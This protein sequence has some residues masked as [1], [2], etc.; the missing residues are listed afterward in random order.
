VIEYKK[1]GIWEQKD[2]IESQIQSLVLEI[3]I[4]IQSHNKTAPSSIEATF[5]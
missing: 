4:K 3:D 5:E 1:Q 2:H